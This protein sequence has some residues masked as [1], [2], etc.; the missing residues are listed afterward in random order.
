MTRNTRISNR[1][2]EPDDT[3]VVERQAI[4]RNGPRV[5]VSR[6]VADLSSD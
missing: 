3:R 1:K 4:Y 6:R 2:E 5:D